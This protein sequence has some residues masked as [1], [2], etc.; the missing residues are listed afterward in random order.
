MS[1]TKQIKL[2]IKLNKKLN[3]QIDLIT[4]TEYYLNRQESIEHLLEQL[5]NIYQDELQFQQELNNN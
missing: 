1:L 4:N 5:N 3:N 2:N